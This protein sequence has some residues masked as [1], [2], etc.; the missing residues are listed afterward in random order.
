MGKAV[1]MATE[2][3]NLTIDDV[4]ILHYDPKSKGAKAYERLARELLELHENG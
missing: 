2:A 3:M 4:T 1:A